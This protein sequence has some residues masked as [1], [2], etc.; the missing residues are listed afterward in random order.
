MKDLTLMSGLGELSV[1][2]DKK[3]AKISDRMK[4]M[5]RANQ[6]VCKK[7]TQ[8]TS[9]LMTLTMMCDAPYR[10]LRQVLAQ[11]E[12][13]RNAIEDTAFKLRRQKIQVKRLREK[14][15]DLAQL[16]AD[17]L[18][19][20]FFRSKSYLE[21]ALKELAT[22][23]DVYDEIK[24]AH[25]IPDNWDELDLEK[26]EIANHIRMAFRNGVRNV[27]VS[28]MMNMGTMEYFEQFGIHP[29]TAYQMIRDYI[30][31]CEQL[32]KD[33]SA[34][35]VDHLYKFL[36]D[37]AETFKDCHKAVMRRIGIADLIK[38]EYLFTEI[39]DAA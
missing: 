34:P 36:D 4:E 19:H 24:E 14:N 28:G 20:G 23:Q 22:Y 7:N 17:E 1:I 11:I 30:D 31:Q 26:E 2:D 10:R 8:A 38:D 15:D 37:C 13:K 12:Q 35:T 33:G 5:D 29:V 32:L 9:Q 21:S 3:L 6:S 25:N 39:R 16:K 27:M 18:E